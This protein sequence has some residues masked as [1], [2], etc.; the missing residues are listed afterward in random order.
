[1]KKINNL[2]SFLNYFNFEKNLILEG[3][4]KKIKK[5]AEE[6]NLRSSFL[7]SDITLSLSY[8]ATNLNGLI[9]EFG[10]L[11]GWSTASLALSKNNIKSY[12]LFENYKFKSGNKNLVS[13]FLK[14]CELDKNSSLIQKDIFKIPPTR[15]KLLF[16]DLSNT[17]EILELVINNWLNYA[18]II[19]FEGGTRERDKYPWMMKYKKKPIREFIKK[20]S[21]KFDDILVYEK[22][23]PG[24]TFCLK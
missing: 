15:C 16:I 24:I 5:I 7:D 20:F 10:V 9:L 1:M 3:R 19:A 2:E 17:G 8:L 18:D 12:D 11:D 22:S 4:Y 23:F 6:L 13:D 14:E 21:N